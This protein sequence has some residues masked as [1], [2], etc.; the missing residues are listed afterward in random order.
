MSR[1]KLGESLESWGHGIPPCLKNQETHTQILRIK[2][3]NLKSQ[4]CKSSRGETQTEYRRRILVE[5][6]EHDDRLHFLEDVRGEDLG[7]SSAFWRIQSSTGYKLRYSLWNDIEEEHEE[8][9]I[10]TGSEGCQELMSRRLQQRISKGGPVN[11]T[12]RWDL[13]KSLKILP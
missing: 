3:V 11:S 5:G 1:Q 9:N 2:Y 13:I 8:E 10:R 12:S 4:I 7:G 6:T